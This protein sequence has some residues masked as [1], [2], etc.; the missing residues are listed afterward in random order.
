MRS[1]RAIVG[2]TLKVMGGVFVVGGVLMVGFEVEWNHS[3]SFSTAHFPGIAL[4]G[5]GILVGELIGR[6]ARKKSN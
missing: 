4:G 5:I 3:F 2:F 1:V 6:T